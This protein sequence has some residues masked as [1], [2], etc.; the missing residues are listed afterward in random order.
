MEYIGNKTI[1]DFPSTTLFFNDLKDI[2]N[3][4][5]GACKEVE[6]ECGDYK[7]TD[8]HELEE[9]ANKFPNGRFEDIYI[10]GYHPHVTL[11]L[12]TFR[13]EAYISESTNEQ[14]GIISR[15]R[16]VILKGKKRKVDWIGHVFTAV[17][18]LASFY[19]TKSK[20]PIMA[21]TLLIESLLSIPVGVNYAMRNN[22]IVY[23]E[24]RSNKKSFFER[25]K[26]ELLI[27]LIVAIG[28]AV[29]T[30]LIPK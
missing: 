20:Q 26:D 25:N 13:I 8:A 19:L 30:F 14:H 2:V 7:I 15:V 21:T 12:R 4:F 18:L 22:V 17:L 1:E 11:E 5:F 16:D 6:I 27:N 29:L 10:R 3:I 23:T 28:T 9:L 24:L